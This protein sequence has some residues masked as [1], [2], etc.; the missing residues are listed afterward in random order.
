MTKALVVSGLLLL[1]ASAVSASPPP[2]AASFL[3]SLKGSCPA[4]TQTP[5]VKK[6]GIGGIAAIPASNCWE[7]DVQ[8]RGNGCCGSGYQEYAIYECIGGFW[9]HVDTFCDS[10]SCF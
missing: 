5:A 9:Q 2:D 3:D 10:V 7:G 8:W 1:C 4:Q 6:D